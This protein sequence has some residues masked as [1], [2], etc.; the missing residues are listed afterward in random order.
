M[1]IENKDDFDAQ[2]FFEELL[3][4]ENDDVVEFGDFNLIKNGGVHITGRMVGGLYDP[5]RMI[6]HD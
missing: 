4:R 1:F 2:L 3:K 6:K 5:G